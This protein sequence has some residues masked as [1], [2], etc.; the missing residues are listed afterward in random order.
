M[1]SAFAG[2]GRSLM[3]IMAAAHSDMTTEEFDEVVKNWLTTAKHPTT[4]RPYSQMVYQPMIELLAYLRA[5][6]FKTFIVS[7]GGIDFM[8]AFAENVYGISPEQVI[9][10][11]GKL[12][13]ELRDGKPV[14][15]KLPALDFFDD[16]E[17]KPIAIQRQ[18]GR[19]PIAAFGNSDGDLQMLQ[20]TC[21]GAGRASA[22]SF[23]T[24]TPSA[25]GPTT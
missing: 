14:L 12:K 18:I 22:S 25:N 1:K 6:G 16:K 23:V 3:E 11:T 2:G 4:G 20:W 8:R 5:N 7:G 17:G 19:R 10:S 9:G 24:P 15:V 13:F 21:A